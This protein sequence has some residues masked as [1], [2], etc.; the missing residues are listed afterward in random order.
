MF[1]EEQYVHIRFSCSKPGD[2][3]VHFDSSTSDYPRLLNL[4]SYGPEEVI[5]ERINESSLFSTGA[6]RAIFKN[7]A[8]K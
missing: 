5:F 6:L 8:K 4:T 3:I 2:L 1:L 7:R